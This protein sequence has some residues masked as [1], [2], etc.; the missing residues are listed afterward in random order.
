MKIMKHAII[1]I[2][3]NN[4]Q[5]VKA[6]MQMLDD[7]RFTFYLLVDQKSEYEPDDFIPKLDHSS[8]VVMN[9]ICIHWGGYSLTRGQVECMKKAL[10]DE[11]NEYFHMFQGAD[12]PLKTPSQID[13]YFTIRKGLNFIEGETSEKASRIMA[14]R[15]SCKH[16]LVDTKLYR[17]HRWIRG[18]DNGLALLQYPFVDKKKKASY[19]SSLYSIHRGLTTHIVSNEKAIRK[20]YRYTLIPDETMAGTLCIGTP[21]EETLVRDAGT[22]LIDWARNAGASPHT[23]TMADKDF[24]LKGIDNENT[25]FARKFHEK[26]D[27]D[28]VYEVMKAVKAQA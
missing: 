5:V 10:E 13:D 17:S 12:L 27:M 23:Y 2:A 3:H 4:T 28:I 11:E 21:F 14:H 6:S 15:I 18:L 7:K 9:R 22:R 26:T 25:M 16:F 20:K 19:E 24:L 8:V 1:I